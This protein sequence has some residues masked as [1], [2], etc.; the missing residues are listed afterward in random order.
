MEWTDLAQGKDKLRAA[1]NTIMNLRVPINAGYFLTE[2]RLAS[3]EGLSCMEL[4][5]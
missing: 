1:V 3:Q 4:I 5:R 2:E